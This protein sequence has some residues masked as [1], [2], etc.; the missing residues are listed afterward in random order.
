MLYRA[1]GDV[2]LCGDAG[3]IDQTES[4]S[5]TQPERQLVWPSLNNMSTK[6]TGMANQLAH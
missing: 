3:N 5:M 4:P 2:L 1:E 6:P